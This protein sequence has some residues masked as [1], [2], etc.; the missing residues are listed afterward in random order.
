MKQAELH[1]D[2]TPT[3]H[4]ASNPASLAAAL[5]EYGKGAIGV[6]TKEGETLVLKPRGSDQM[7]K[8][9]PEKS[10][11]WRALDVAV[12]QRMIF[13][14]LIA[15]YFGQNDGT[16]TRGYTADAND[17]VARVKAGEFQVAFLLQPTPVRALA[18]LGDV[19]EVMPQ[20]ST[21]FYPKLA[22]GLVMNPLK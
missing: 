5:A 9:E 7:R 4:G 22:T 11:A 20:K 13:D 18:E 6:Y 21:Y 17:A 2:I 15:K 12:F 19:G 14:E 1:F 3:K 8:L 16:M 10:D